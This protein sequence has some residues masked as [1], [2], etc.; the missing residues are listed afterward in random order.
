M[1]YFIRSRNRASSEGRRGLVFGSHV[2]P[3]LIVVNAPCLHDG[4][5][6]G[7]GGEP[8]DVKAFIM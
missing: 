2:R 5:N 6:L 4:L 1:A 3:N 8:V 7:Q